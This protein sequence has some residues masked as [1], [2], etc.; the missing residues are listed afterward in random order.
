MRLLQGKQRERKSIARQTKPPLTKY[1]RSD[2]ASDKPSP[3]NKRVKKQSLK[4]I[5]LA[6]ADTLA[7]VA[8]FLVIAYSLA[9][10][11]SPLVKSTSS[12]YH[13]QQTYQ[14]AVKKEL[15]GIKNRNKFTFDEQ[16]ISQT[17]KRQFP[18]I[19]SVSVELPIFSPKPTIRLTIAEPSFIL[20]SGSQL[21]IVSSSGR[22]ITSANGFPNLASLI[23]VNDETGFRSSLGQQVIS[24]E[25][26]AFLDNLLAQS[27]KNNVPI[28][29]LT[30]PA[31][32]QELHLRTSDTNY[33]VKFFLDGDSDT[34]I[35]QFLAARH[36][37]EARGV[38]P[39]E[40]L[41]VRVPG[42]IYYK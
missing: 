30:L 42:R 39:S 21:Y 24:K 13:N 1:Y 2:G 8:L 11:D 12:A 22:A 5:L 7:I 38:S 9:V 23:V 36:N 10:S 20:N 27:K 3:F 40:Y 31:K 34:Q 28:S 25:G 18:E 6:S 16:K 33:F 41:D 37:F 29:N 19:S 32:A 4:K 17:L 26:V 35:G 14:A 15:S